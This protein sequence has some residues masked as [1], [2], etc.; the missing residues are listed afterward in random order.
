MLNFYVAAAQH[1]EKKLPLD[2]QNL[3]DLV[4]LHPQ[5][6]QTKVYIEDNTRLTRQLPHSLKEMK[7]HVSVMSRKLPKVNQY[8]QTGM[9]QVNFISYF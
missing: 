8:L 6:R 3:K 5:S 9:K 1:L 2:S 7:L 4:A